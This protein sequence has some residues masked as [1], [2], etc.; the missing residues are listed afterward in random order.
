MS[1]PA[2]PEMRNKLLSILPAADYAHVV[3]G[4]EHVDL[5][6][7]MVLAEAGQPIDYV[8]FLTS[9]IGSL[10]TTTPDGNH[11]EAGIFGFDG[12][13]P[14]S[15]MAN[16]ELS[17]HDIRVQIAGDGYRMSYGTFRH[18]MD[19][20]RNFSRVVLR[21]IE[22][23]SVQL[24]HTAVSNAV[25]EVNQRL[26]RWLLMCHD[27]VTGNEI[28]ITHEFISHMLAVR[29]PSVTVALQSLE[30]ERFIE[31]ERG[32]ITIRNRPGLEQFAHDAYGKPEREYR[33][34]MK[35]LF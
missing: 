28:P 2:Q 16:V 13:L 7:F 32:L 21:S 17:S 27:R 20:N 4:L 35:D 19:E 11:A 9:G 26:A 31:S 23:F 22:A 12:Y 24:A 8:Y 25:H 33:R 3:A 14:T 1:G 18:W 10:V 15:A 30:G 34:L 29:R 6:R 5:P